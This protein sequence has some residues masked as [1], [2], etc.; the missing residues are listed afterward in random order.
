MSSCTTSGIGTDT[1]TT[2][3]TA[4]PGGL[5]TIQLP[6]NADVIADVLAA[7]PDEVDGV[8]RETTESNVVTYMEGRERHLQ[9]DVMEIASVREF[10]GV[11]DMTVVDFLSGMVDSGEMEAVESELDDSRPLVWL[12]SETRGDGRLLHVAN[13]GHS[14]GEWVFSAIADTPEARTEIIR[15]FVDAAKSTN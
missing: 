9:L 8:P 7:M 14:D 12:T 10:S 6:D 15:A 13:W 3:A 4:A 1:E 5:D 11:P 2:E